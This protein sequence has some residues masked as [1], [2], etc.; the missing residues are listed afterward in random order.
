MQFVC[1]SAN[2]TQGLRE[3]PDFIAN[4]KA[5]QIFKQSRSD[6]SKIEAR[7]LNLDAIRK[8]YREKRQVDLCE[9]EAGMVHV[10]SSRTIK[11]T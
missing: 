2:R 11:A 3:S 7:N 6:L 1:A 5:R 4:R 10:E 9:F 8:N